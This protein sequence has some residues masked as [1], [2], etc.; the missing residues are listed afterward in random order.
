VGLVWA[1]WQTGK[2]KGLLDFRADPV[3]VVVT[4][5]Y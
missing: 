3:V 5:L 2:E 4:V 1:V